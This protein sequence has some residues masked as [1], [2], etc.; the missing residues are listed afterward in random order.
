MVLFYHRSASA[1][2][3]QKYSGDESVCVG[4]FDPSMLS[5]REYQSLLFIMPNALIGPV[6]EACSRTGCRDVSVLITDNGFPAEPIRIDV[7]KPRLDYMETELA[8]VCNLHCRGCAG[9]IQL[10][11]EEPPFYDPDAFVRDLRQLK[12]KFWG[13]ERMRLM[14][15]EPLLV[16]KID[17]YAEHARTV[18]PDADIRIVTNGLL[19]P[20]LS[21]DT[22]AG[23]KKQGVS[24]DISNYPPTARKKKEIVS[25]LRDAGISYNFGPPIRYF[26][27]NVS[28]EPSGNA[29]AAFDNCFFPN[30]HM[31]NEGGILTPCSFAYC[32]R[33]YNRHFGTNYSE[34][35]YIDLYKT[36]KDGWQI[37]HWLSHPHAFCASCTAGM[38]PIR[39]R[40][41]IQ[42]DDAVEG[43]WIIPKNVWT[44]HVIPFAQR[45]MIPGAK[46]LR[47][48]VQRNRS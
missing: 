31:M 38:V 14:G 43:D 26:F 30:C 24:F 15:G 11:G 20:S 41:G 34:D 39:W 27:K 45:L 35:D 46:A 9:F 21:A 5:G 4:R 10:A 8:R 44:D 36:E 16:K 29:K 40:D 32:I 2:L 18:F 12:K 13:V 33:R 42:R 1:A 19:V 47:S 7:S 17:A 37:L 22:L 28:A 23:L 6:T 25:V 3:V 48:F